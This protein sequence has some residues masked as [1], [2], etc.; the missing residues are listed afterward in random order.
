M[1]LRLPARACTL[2]R[3][4]DLPRR[5]A[6]EL[7]RDTVAFSESVNETVVALFG[8]LSV[9]L[10]ERR[11][12]RCPPTRRRRRRRVVVAGGGGVG[13][14]RRRRRRRVR[15]RGRRSASGPVGIVLVLAGRRS[16]VPGHARVELADERVGRRACRRCTCPTVPGRR[17]LE[18]AGRVG[19]AP[20]AG[21]SSLIVR[22]GRRCAPA[23]WNAKVTDSPVWICDGRGRRPCP[24]GPRL[25]SPTAVIVCRPRRRA[26]DRRR[27]SACRRPR[28]SR[29]C[30]AG[31]WAPMLPH[32]AHALA[33]PRTQLLSPS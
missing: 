30:H 10:L 23:P 29:A 17:D 28:A 14:R 27:R 21:R 25:P 13:R 32:C 24:T 11:R 33:L 7:E 2:H 3:A 20:S 12:R 26:G 15:R 1:T 16:T 8:A 22:R 4:Q 31:T 18:G 19:E 9:T 6:A 5:R